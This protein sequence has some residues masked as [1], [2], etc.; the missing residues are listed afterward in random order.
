MIGT[1]Q[2]AFAGYEE[3]V[4]QDIIDAVVSIREKK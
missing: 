1:Q 3:D 2:E 4:I